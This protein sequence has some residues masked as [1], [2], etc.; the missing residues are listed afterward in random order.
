L[1]EKEIRRLEKLLHIK[2]GSDKLASSFADEGLDELLDFC[3]DKKRKKMLR[4]E[5]KL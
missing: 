2:K 5:G 4:K 3:D 1:E